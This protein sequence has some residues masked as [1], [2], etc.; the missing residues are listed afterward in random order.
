MSSQLNI[1]I[2]SRYPISLTQTVISHG[3]VQLSP[4]N[5]N[6]VKKKLS[7]TEQ[8]HSGK[9]VDITLGQLSAK[10][11]SIQ[12]NCAVNGVE[13]NQIK[14]IVSRWISIDWD[15]RPAVKISQSLDPR[16]ALFIKLGG[17]RFLRSTTFYED[18]V[19]TICTVNAN[20]SFTSRMV[21][22][23]VGQLGDG[24]FPTPQ[25]LIN[26]GEETLR[27]DYRLGF[28]ARVLVELST[29]ML[30]D[31][32]IDGKGNL[33]KTVLRFEDLLQLRG[34]GPYSG[35]HLMMLNHDY[36]HIPIDSEVT[37]YCRESYGLEPETIESYFERWGDYKFLGYKLHR[38][39][40]STKWTP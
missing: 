33:I 14:S 9:L 35:N 38:I 39:L 37:L 21:S 23:L 22:N 31:G 25:Q 12:T 28:R 34:V 15:P 13:T 6:I 29:H 4:W 16:I 8:L 26:C 20:W 11:I 40:N 10:N 32:W 3:W 27:S 36:S 17:G 5:W 30:N 24:L 18:F 19:K 7:R 1:N 2:F